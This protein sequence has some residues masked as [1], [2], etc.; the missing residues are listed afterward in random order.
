MESWQGA[1]GVKTGDDT[2]TKRK[3]LTALTETMAQAIADVKEWQRD[4]NY[5]TSINLDERTAELVN[6][7]VV[8]SHIDAIHRAIIEVA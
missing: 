8:L 4:V 2:M 3:T 7:A 1:K 5:D 6:M